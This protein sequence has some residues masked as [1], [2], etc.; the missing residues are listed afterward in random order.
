MSNVQV[1]VGSKGMVIALI[2]GV[3]LLGGGGGYLLWRVNQEK[4]VAPTESEAG[5]WACTNPYDVTYYLRNGTEKTCKACT[6]NPE[7]P[8]GQSCKGP[9]SHSHYYYECGKYC[10]YNSCGKEA[11]DNIGN[12]KPLPKFTL[13]YKADDNGKVDNPGPHTVEQGK[14]GPPV[15]ASPKNATT[16]QF[17]QWSDGNKSATRTDTNVQ[18]NATYTAQFIPVTAQKF[19]LTYTAGTG[20]S[21]VGNATQT[22]EKG[23]DG[24]E[25]E[26]KANT[27]YKFVK[28]DDGVNTAKRTDK[29]VQKNIT[30]KAEFKASCG[31]SIC[32]PWENMTS[33]PADCKGCGDGKCVPPENATTC[34]Q[35]CPVTCGDGICSEGEDATT[36]P[37]DCPVTC[38]DGICSDGENANTCPAD[39]K[40]VCG[41]G[42]CTKGEDKDN[43]PADCGTVPET[44]IFDNSKHTMIFGAVILMIGLAWTWI[45]TLPKKAYKLVSNTSDS[46]SKYISDV[47]VKQEKNVRESRRN[48]LERR[49]K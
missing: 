39:C 36:C 40:S 23:K 18:A 5:E 30:A 42:L 29:N 22:V 3:L 2:I 14:S 41:D 12:P 6:A 19:T 15:T 9:G 35:D 37:Q 44:G 38:G 16:H 1:K 28:W 25:V 34:P 31:D 45:A 27:N 32:D 48:K 21:I 4:T 8:T 24:T 49:I 46:V 17:S 10:F 7:K 47:K 20:G 13:T 11:C 43:C 33:C 26:A